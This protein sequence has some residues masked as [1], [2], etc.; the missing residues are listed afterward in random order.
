MPAAYFLSVPKAKRHFKLCVCWVVFTIKY[1]PAPI[2]SVCGLHFYPAISPCNPISPCSLPPGGERVGGTQ[3][4][5][6]DPGRER[7]QKEAD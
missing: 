5:L 4:S 7:Q 6:P 2:T 1:P 3:M